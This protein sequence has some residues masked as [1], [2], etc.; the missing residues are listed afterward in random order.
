MQVSGEGEGGFAQGFGFGPC[1]VCFSQ[2]GGNLVLGV[3]LSGDIERGST[4][5]LPDYLDDA[6]KLALLLWIDIRLAFRR[7]PR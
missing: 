4:Q 5:P 7:A 1:R 3:L 2:I 6:A